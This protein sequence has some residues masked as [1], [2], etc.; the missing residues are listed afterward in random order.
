[1][2]NLLSPIIIINLKIKYLKHKKKLKKKT[3]WR[4]SS[5]VTPKFNAIM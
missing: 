5:Q 4:I 2:L 3:G 1:M